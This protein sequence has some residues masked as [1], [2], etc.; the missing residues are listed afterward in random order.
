MYAIEAALSL[1]LLY[2]LARVGEK[3]AGEQRL[4]ASLL[5]MTLSLLPIGLATS[6]PRACSR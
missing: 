5:L 4:M 6:L 3:N 2:P 1:S